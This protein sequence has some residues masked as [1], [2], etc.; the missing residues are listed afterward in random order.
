MA[1]PHTTAAH[2]K[3]MRSH[4]RPHA[5]DHVLVGL[6]IEIDLEKAWP[7]FGAP[8]R[9][10]INDSAFLVGRRSGKPQAFHGGKP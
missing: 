4:L 2:D 6:R 10:R 1:A 5:F 3:N 7:I 8:R 9:E